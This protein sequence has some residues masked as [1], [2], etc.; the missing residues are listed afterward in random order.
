[1]RSTEKEATITDV[2]I[3]ND[4]LS[5]TVEGAKIL[6]KK[7][8]V[9]NTPAP[10]VE[11]VKEDTAA[12][13]TTVSDDG[14]NWDRTLDECDALVDKYIVVARKAKMRDPI[15]I[16]QY[17]ALVEKAQDLD[18]QLGRAK[19]YNQLSKAQLKRLAAMQ[20]KMMAAALELDSQL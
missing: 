5:M 12:T 18:N 20:N 15:A 2:E 10:V 17:P 3:E 19:T 14:P 6:A 11:T 16:R 4:I 1:M 7:V 13:E 8:E 9:S